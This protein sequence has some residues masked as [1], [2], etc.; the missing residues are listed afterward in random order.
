MVD[1]ESKK[2]TAK[3]PKSFLLDVPFK[4]ASPNLQIL[5]EPLNKSTNIAAPPFSVKH[6]FKLAITKILLDALVG[7]IDADNPVSTNDVDVVVEPV[8]KVALTTCNTLPAGNRALGKVPVVM[9]D[10]LGTPLA[11]EAFCI[12]LT[13][14]LFSVRW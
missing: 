9:F 6:P 3:S 1:G 4:P 13:G 7:V 12:K 10:A 11:N 8:E 2:D 14:I 5:E